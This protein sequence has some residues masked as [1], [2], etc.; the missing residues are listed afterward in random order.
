MAES[1]VLEVCGTP[2]WLM[3]GCC[4][5]IGPMH[6]TGNNVGEMAFQMQVQ[7]DWIRA[8]IEKAENSGF[9]YDSKQSILAQSK[10][11]LDG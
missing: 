1:G 4:R 8:K 2:I 6:C 10:S 9:T 3:V 7:I 5:T 11:L